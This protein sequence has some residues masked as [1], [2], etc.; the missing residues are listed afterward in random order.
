M[1]MCSILEMVP[2]FRLSQQP[3]PSPYPNDVCNLKEH[4]VWP[5]T[6]LWTYCSSRAYDILFRPRYLH[7]AKNSPKGWF[8]VKIDMF[9][10]AIKDSVQGPESHYVLMEVK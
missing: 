2:Q 9:E 5:D 6:W 10:R 8:H 3:Y 1:E 7:E 4:R